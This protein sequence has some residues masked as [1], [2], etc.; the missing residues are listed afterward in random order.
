[1]T[2]AETLAVARSYLNAVESGTTA[3][4]RRHLTTDFVQREWPN[5]MSPQGASRNLP[6]V[7]QAAEQGREV[8]AD[9]V[10]QIATEAVDGDRVILE[11]NW[12]ATLRVD[13]PDA[14]TGTR[15]R[16]RVAIFLQ[17]RDGRVASQD[18]YDHYLPG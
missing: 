8:V 16:A 17:I 15:I 14:P 4:L 1:M 6:E 12:S 10:F 11:V 3:E 13:F 18:N 2:R 5:P 7:L 9:Q